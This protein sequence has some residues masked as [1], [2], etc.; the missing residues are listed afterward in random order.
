MTEDLIAADTV[1]YYTTGELPQ[2]FRLAMD[3][4]LKRWLTDAGR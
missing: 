4:K 3:K 1:R 2:T